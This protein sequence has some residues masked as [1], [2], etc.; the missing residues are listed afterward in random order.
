MYIA[1]N[2]TVK[3]LRGVPLDPTYDHTIYF[4]PNE[5]GQNAQ[6]LYFSRLTKYNLTEQTYQ[7]VKKGWLRVGIVADN[8]YDC[9]YIMFQNTNF[10][11][12]WFYAFIKS[13]EYINNTVSEIEFEIDVMQTWNLE[14]TLDMCYVEREHCAA[15]DTASLYTPE[16]IETGDLMY[17]MADMIN[18]N[19]MNVA[20]L[21]TPQNTTPA[22]NYFNTYFGVAVSTILPLSDLTSVQ[23]VIDQMVTQNQQILALYQ[24]PSVFQTGVE[25]QTVT[26]HPTIARPTFVDGTFSGGNRYTPKNRKLLFY[27]FSFIR[28]SAHNG[29][30]HDYAYEYFTNDCEFYVKCVNIPDVTVA[31]YPS[32]YKSDA[33]Y[34]EKM[35]IKDFPVCAWSTDSFEQWWAN[36]KIGVFFDGI[37]KCVSMVGGAALL[38]ANAGVSSPE[39]QTRQANNYTISN[40]VGIQNSLLGTAASIMQAHQLP[41]QVTGNITTGN[42]N[43]GLNKQEIVFYAMSVKKERAIC[44]DEYFDRYGYATKR[45][46]IPNRRVR[47][48]WTYTKTIGCTITGSIPCDDARKIC[49]IYNSGI[50]FW[51]HGNEVGNYNLDNT[52][53]E[54]EVVNNG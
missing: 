40:A 37:S 3:I 39:M 33:G 12:K 11:A 54:T 13:V 1:P 41:N 21:A 23:N 5:S 22:H 32:G 20:I 10:G 4:D 44:I 25:G 46:K 42:T 49:D 27:P 35:L 24:V 48:H 15:H 9:N 43:A 31:V 36:N 52:V 29:D 8:L 18:L 38:S 19:D 28:V 30:S 14:Y 17:R 50:T 53:D 34:E 2:T 47:P 6:Y 45:N 51:V 7:R 16:N 26:L